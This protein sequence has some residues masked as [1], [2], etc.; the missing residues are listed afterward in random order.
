[1]KALLAAVLPVLSALALA[2][3]G[4]APAA[5]RYRSAAV[6]RW[7][8]VDRDVADRVS[9][10]APDRPGAAH[11]TNPPRAARVWPC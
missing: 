4:A 8:S 6:T 5:D 9:D 2:L 10:G 7:I 3:P 11:R 1:M